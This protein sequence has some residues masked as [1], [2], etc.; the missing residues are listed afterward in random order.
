MIATQI[1]EARAWATPDLG[2]VPRANRNVLHWWWSASRLDYL[3]GNG[4]R[5]CAGQWNLTLHNTRPRLV[6]GNRGKAR[7]MRLLRA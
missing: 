5:A 2:G 1:G 4:L 7:R 3:D 6:T